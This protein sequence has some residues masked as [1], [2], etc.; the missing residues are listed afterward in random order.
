LYGD[1]HDDECTN[2]NWD[3]TVAGQIMNLVQDN[4]VRVGTLPRFLKGLTVFQFRLKLKATEYTR[5]P[6]DIE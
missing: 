4:A 6:K 3:I 1:G 5:Y 2:A